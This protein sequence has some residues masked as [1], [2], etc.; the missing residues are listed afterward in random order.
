MPRTTKAVTAKARHK[1]VLNATK[2]HYGASAQAVCEGSQGAPAVGVEGSPKL[3]RAA[4]NNLVCS[5][6]IVLPGC[7]C[8]I[9]KSGFLDDACVPA[10]ANHVQQEGPA[11]HLAVDRAFLTD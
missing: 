2:G 9:W 6:E 8:I 7:W 1:K 3:S 5:G 10:S 11:I 4:L